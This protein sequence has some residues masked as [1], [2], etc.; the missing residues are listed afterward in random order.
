MLLWRRPFVEC[1]N[2]WSKR[3]NAQATL[4]PHHEA[5]VKAGTRREDVKHAALD[6]SHSDPLVRRRQDGT[7]RRHRVVAK[8]SSTAGLG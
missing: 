4:R 6:V 7:I 5:G 8:A 3:A 2:N 1:H